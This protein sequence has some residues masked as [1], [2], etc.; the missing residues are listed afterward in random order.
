MANKKT[1][2]KK[3]KSGGKSAGSKGGGSDFD[4]GSPKPVRKSKKK[5]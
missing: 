3:P 5:K 1:S 2:T 4:I